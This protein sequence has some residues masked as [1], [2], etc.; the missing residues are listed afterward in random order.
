MTRAAVN[1]K[2]WNTLLLLGLFA[3][4]LQLGPVACNRTCGPREVRQGPLCVAPQDGGAAGSSDTTAAGATGGMSST[5][6][7]ASSS[8]PPNGSTA[9]GPASTG[10]VRNGQQMEAGA[11]ASTPTSSNSLP[12]TAGVG[13]SSTG[14]QGGNGAA[15]APKADAGTGG[16]NAGSSAGGSPGSPQCTPAMEVCDGQ[17]NDCDNQIDE[18]VPP[19]KCGNEK[20]ICKAGTIQCRAGKWDDPQ[21]QC[22][23]AVGPAPEGEQCD[24]ARADENCDGVANE[25]CACTEGETM[26][27]ST[28]PY[29]CT[30]GTVACS[31]GKFSSVCEG[32]VQGT[33]EK[34]DGMD[35]DCDNIPDNGGDRLCGGSMPYCDGRNGCVSCRTAADCKAGACQTAACVNGSCRPTDSAA[36]TP[37]T[38]GGTVCN[39]SGKC[40]ACMKPSDCTG[41][42]TLGA[43]ERATCTS[44]NQCSKE[45]MCKTNET[46]SGAGACVSTVT[47][48][49]SP[50]TGSAESCG[51]GLICS[52]VNVC[53]QACTMDSQCPSTTFRGAFCY[54]KLLCAVNCKDA[55]ECPSG[56]GYACNTNYTT[57]TESGK[58]VLG[59][60]N[61]N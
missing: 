59:V 42:L 18:D 56:Y 3:A 12:N 36:G 34:C 46:C 35:N 33:A 21:T 2:S 20:G 25:G 57:T 44:A 43:C 29:T 30:K 16:A 53:T 9:G 1:P 26:P 41:Q 28:G 10:T 37:C 4:A 39:G 55:S 61:K 14:A 15:N 54:N 60:C 5:S 19:Q 49:Y 58:V 24:A 8:S 50:C 27:C 23:G 40:V 7:G 45:S 47:E 38:S 48:L 32:E 31:N 52:S 51:G 6:P 17:D 22:Q 13:V 11:S